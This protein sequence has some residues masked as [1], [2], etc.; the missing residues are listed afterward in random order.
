MNNCLGYIL[1]YG[2]TATID[3]Q[4]AYFYYHQAAML[5]N[6]ESMVK[7]ADMYKNGY[8]VKQDLAI[9]VQKIKES[10]YV[11]TRLARIYMEEGQYDL[12]SFDGCGEKLMARITKIEESCGFLGLDVKKVW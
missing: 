2:R 8:Y 9:Y 10:Y 11:Y 1:Y 4:K 5:G 12:F 6:A 3:H 7:I